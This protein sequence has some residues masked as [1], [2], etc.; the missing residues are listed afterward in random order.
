MQG[1]K[2]TETSEETT[3]EVRPETGLLEENPSV[4]VHSEE[5]VPLTDE[6]STDMLIDDN[7]TVLLETPDS[8]REQRSGGVEI[9][10]LEE[11]MYVHTDEAIT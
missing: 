4:A 9:S 7:E 3:D 1:Q 6:L 2:K 8:S 10:I 11:I 5:T